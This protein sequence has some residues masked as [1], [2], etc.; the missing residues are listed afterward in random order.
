MAP[1]F[2]QGDDSEEKI[3]PFGLNAV[4]LRGSHEGYVKKQRAQSAIEG[5]SKYTY[6]VLRRSLMGLDSSVVDSRTEGQG[7][8]E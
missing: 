5:S 7:A 4:S 3:E 1:K 2:H 6:D 8:L